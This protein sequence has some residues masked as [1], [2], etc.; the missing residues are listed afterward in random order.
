MRAEPNGFLVHHLSHS[1]TVS[2]I[3]CNYQGRPQISHIPHTPK[4]LHP[5]SRS[6]YRHPGATVAQSGGPVQW[7]GPVAKSTCPVQWYSPVAQFSGTVQWNRPAVQCIGPVQ[8]PSPLVQ[9]SVPAQC[10]SALVQSTGPFHVSSPVVQPT[11]HRILQ[12]PNRLFATL[13]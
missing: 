12:N 6:S 3:A 4:M 2:M 8:W 13:R 5:S 7:P 11:L 1:V 10:P 9:S